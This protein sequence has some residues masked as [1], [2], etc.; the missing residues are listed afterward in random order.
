[1][2]QTIALA[3]SELGVLYQMMGLPSIQYFNISHSIFH[4]QYFTPAQKTYQR[5]ADPASGSGC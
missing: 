1:M 3:S 4:I 5:T 2:S